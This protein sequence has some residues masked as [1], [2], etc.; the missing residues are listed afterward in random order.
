ML[1]LCKALWVIE[2]VCNV[3]LLGGVRC[4][5]WHHSLFTLCHYALYRT[6]DCSSRGFLSPVGMVRMFPVGCRSVVVYPD[7]PLYT[8]TQLEKSSPSPKSTKIG[9]NYN[10]QYKIVHRDTSD[11]HQHSV[12]SERRHNSQRTPPRGQTSHTISMTHK[13]L[14]RYNM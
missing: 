12:N 9:V 8:G 1:Y 10:Q 11:L 3:S 4:E 14:H 13:T 2:L 7:T 6:A 5:F